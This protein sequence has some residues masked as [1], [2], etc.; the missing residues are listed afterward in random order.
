[1]SNRPL[2]SGDLE[3]K[4]EG[5]ET[6][7]VAMA[8]SAKEPRAVTGAFEIEEGGRFSIGLKDTS[9]LDSRARMTGA[10]ALVDDKR[11]FVRIA[12]PLQ[13]SYA[14]PNAAL[15]IA[16]EADDDFGVKELKVFRSLNDSR[17]LP[18]DVTP[19]GAQLTEVQADLELPLGMYGLVPGDVLTFYARVVDNDPAAPK[20]AESEVAQVV[21]ISQ[22]DFDRL[23]ASKA[24][25]EELLTKYYSQERAIEAL[26]ERMDED[27]KKLQE[28]KPEDTAA[29]EEL[30]KEIE[31]LAKA[32]REQ[33]QSAAEAAGE[34]PLFDID[35]TLAQQLGELATRLE[36]AA[37]KT[38]SASGNMPGAQALSDL[39]EARRML[40]E[41]EDDYQKDAVQ[42]LEALEKVYPLIEDQ[43][44]FTQLYLKQKDLARRMKSLADM[45]D[46]STPEAKVRAADLADEQ[47][48][49]ADEL[50]QLSEDIRAHALQM[51]E[52]ARFEEL[53]RTAQEFADKL[54]NSGASG[55]ME[56]AGKSLG[57]K[58]AK[59]AADHAE[60]AAE[61]L[62]GL[63]KECESAQGQATDAL[64]FQP[65]LGQGIEA[66][67]EQLLE[68]AGLSGSNPG[69]QGKG[70]AGQGGLRDAGVVAWERGPLRING[71]GGGVAGRGA[72]ESRRAEREHQREGRARRAGGTR[73]GAG[74]RGERRGTH[75]VG[76]AA[77]QGEGAGVFQGRGGRD[78][79]QIARE[80]GGR[81]PEQE[82][83]ARPEAAP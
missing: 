79:A 16:I 42:P 71:Q 32:L 21:I 10:L 47:A 74:R 68:G 39:Q 78:R 62:R 69:G 54:D 76:A 58:E 27:I 26:K 29:A 20:G 13:Y 17:D 8:P 46:L 14:T 30:K 3:V 48:Q 56:N 6:A 73:D 15:P 66:T 33:S 19:Q 31:D 65:G 25:L 18:L 64:R 55:E 44:R 67:L 45:K 36:E 24:N 40:G 59:A 22:E 23:T 52:G 12:H 2:A 61:I 34:K 77:V 41:A 72:E 37:G 83:Q 11:P 35:K 81:R 38:Q 4:W 63:L 9:G 60:N 7:R 57:E 80:A 82:M 43:A 5:G 75:G 1:M 50:K 51:P 49:L 70:V 28:L 53:A